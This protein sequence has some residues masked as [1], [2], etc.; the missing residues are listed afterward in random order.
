MFG[1]FGKRATAA[2][3]PVQVQVIPSELWQGEIGQAMR[4]AGMRPDD[5][6]NIV[7][8]SNAVDARVAQAR[9]ALDLRV[10]QE[11]A[12][13]ARAHPGCSLAPMHIFTEMVWNGPHRQLLL[14]T[15][16]LTPYDQWNVRLVAADQRSSERLKQPRLYAGEIP[17]FQD[18]INDLLGQ[19]VAEHRASANFKHDMT[20]DIWGL[21]NYF[22]EEHIR[23]GLAD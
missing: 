18:S 22:W 6:A 17:Q 21:S 23:P 15:L 3:Q 19:L 14:E 7:T 10:E 12:A 2:A 20:R 8:F 16:E 4:D 5:A 11:N 1:L 13:I 9:V